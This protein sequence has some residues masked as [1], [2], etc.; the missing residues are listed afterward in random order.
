MSVC[1]RSDCL[2]K[3]TVACLTCRRNYPP[4]RDNL[5]L[6]KPT[7]PNGYV[8]CVLDPAY[9][10]FYDEE[11]YKEIYGDI[12]PEEASKLHCKAGE[13]NCYDDEDK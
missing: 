9:L 7:C 3:G 6:Y 10:K 11:Y 13:R 2:N 1:N 4:L 5:V 12:T 8:D